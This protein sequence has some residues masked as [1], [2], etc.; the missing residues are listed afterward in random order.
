M[1]FIFSLQMINLKYVRRH[2]FWKISFIKKIVFNIES[3]SPSVVRINTIYYPGWAVLDNGKKTNINYDNDL[4]VMDIEIAQGS[5][6]IS[7][8]F[9]ETKT[10][11]LS[12]TISIITLFALVAILTIYTSRLFIKKWKF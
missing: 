6:N 12:D 10:R 4:G 8:N 9:S 3:D 1:L 11:L 2:T 5:H 7:A